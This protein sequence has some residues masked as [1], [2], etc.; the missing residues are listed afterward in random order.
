MTREEAIRLI[1]DAVNADHG[2]VKGEETLEQIEWDS[3]ASVSFIALVDEHLNREL[4][5]KVVA[6]CKTVPDLLAIL[7]EPA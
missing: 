7:V 1:E 4:D 3:M 2:H 5:A 6:R